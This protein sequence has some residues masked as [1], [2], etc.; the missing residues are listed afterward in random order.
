ME[1]LK[2]K[3]LSYKLFESETS[4]SKDLILSI[5]NENLEEVKELWFRD[6]AWLLK[7]PSINRKKNDENYTFDNCEF[8]ELGKNIAEMAV[9]VH[10]IP[11]VQFDLQGYFLKEWTS[12]REVERVLGIKNS[13][14]TRAIKGRR[15]TA[16]GFI[17]RY[18]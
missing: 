9:R 3:I 13:N 4:I 15:P 10:S 6:S 11:I 17:W 5:K 1:K 16:G 7:N 2:R 18:K 14:I 12:A 8:I